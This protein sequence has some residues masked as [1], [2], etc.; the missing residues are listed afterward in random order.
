MDG[1]HV[2]VEVKE[3]NDEFCMGFVPPINLI[4]LNISKLINI[5]SIRWVINAIN[6]SRQVWI[7]LLIIAVVHG[8]SKLNMNLLN[9]LV[10][11]NSPYHIGINGASTYLIVILDH[12]GN[13]ILETNNG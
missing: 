10:T 7:P 6:V 5:E 2:L 4:I 12:F 13:N 9:P 1:M 3:S 11:C 8:L